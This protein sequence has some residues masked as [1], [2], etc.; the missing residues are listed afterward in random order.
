MLSGT[1]YTDLFDI[2]YKECKH[3]NNHVI[4]IHIH[5]DKDLKLA[6]M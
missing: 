4:Q 6:V 1:Y 5:R 2:K 3:G